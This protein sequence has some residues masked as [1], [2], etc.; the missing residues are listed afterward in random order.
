MSNKEIWSRYLEGEGDLLEVEEISSLMSDLRNLV[1]SAA[2]AALV[3]ASTV[4]QNEKFPALHEYQNPIQGALQQEFVKGFQAGVFRQNEIVNS[5][6]EE[7]DELRK[8]R[9]EINAQHE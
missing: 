6:L 1:K 5:W 4:A 3:K 9:A 8:L 7:L 2:W